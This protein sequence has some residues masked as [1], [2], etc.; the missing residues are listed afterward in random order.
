MEKRKI[1]LVDRL[2]DRGFVDQWGFIIFA[3][4]GFAGIVSGKWL[5]L[6]TVWVAIGAIALM[7]LY[8]VYV[9]WSAG[10]RVRADQAGDNCY[11]LGLIYTLASLSYA[12]GTFDPNDAAST[13]VQGFGIALA[14]TILGLILRV[15]FSQGRP[16]LENVEEL[17]RLELTEAS[18]RLKAEL[19]EV[20]RN[21]ND[22]SR[23]MQQSISELHEAATANMEDFAKTSVD[24]LRSVI[25]AANEAISA[26]ANDFASRSKKYDASFSKLLTKL[27]AHSESLQIINDT[28]SS[29]LLAAQSTDNAVNA[30]NVSLSELVDVSREAGAMVTHARDIGSATSQ[31]AERMAAAVSLVEQ[32]LQ[33]IR[34]ETETQLKALRDGPSEVISS[35][36]TSLERASVQLE[37]EVGK[38]ADAHGVVIAGLTQQSGAALAT[39]SKHNEEIEAELATSRNAVSRVHNALVE[40]TDQLVRHVEKTA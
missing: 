30:T 35:V 32:N 1:P 25:D 20:V 33:A 28:H 14:T 21:M 23:N 19:G 34:G 17:A 26:E 16:D 18:S 31:V 38:V 13:I 3:T 8:A 27:D 9:G 6:A 15:F 12:I 24:G 22:F 37:Q 39:V 40:M 36:L 11:Y 4:F 2:R 5:G 10:G 29:L 7:L